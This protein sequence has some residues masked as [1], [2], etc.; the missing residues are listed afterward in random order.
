[1]MNSWIYWKLGLLNNTRNCTCDDNIRFKPNLCKIWTF[2]YAQKIVKIIWP[3]KFKILGVITFITNVDFQLNYFCRRKTFYN[4][5]FKFDI[6]GEM[7]YFKQNNCQMAQFFREI[8]I[9]FFEAHPVCIFEIW[10]AVENKKT[11][12]SKRKY[13]SGRIVSNKQCSFDGTE[14]G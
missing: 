14:R 4:E 9:D 6:H 3:S 12:N 2:L 5:E 8:Y 1:M 13:E 10:L 7:Q 11:C